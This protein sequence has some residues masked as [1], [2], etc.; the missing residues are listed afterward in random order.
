[1]A[2]EEGQVNSASTDGRPVPSD[3]KP[4]S[5]FVVWHYTNEWSSL[6]LPLHPR[7]LSTWVKA[8]KQNTQ[9]NKNS[10]AHAFQKD[11]FSWLHTKT[12][13]SCLRKRA[14]PGSSVPTAC[15]WM[16]IESFIILNLLN[17]EIPQ[18][19][20]RG[21]LAS[22]WAKKKIEI[23]K[24]NSVSEFWSNKMPINS[25]LKNWCFLPERCEHRLH[26]STELLKTFQKVWFFPLE[27]GWLE[28]RAGHTRENDSCKLF[29]R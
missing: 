18:R 26:Y 28:D 6:P 21:L 8:R 10:T 22:Y 27:M 23:Q 24:K 1:M 13:Q 7:V 20:L 17:F 12:G 5:C 9:T 2:S 29:S 19:F 4:V 16:V 25:P 15:L 11:T 3:R 14:S